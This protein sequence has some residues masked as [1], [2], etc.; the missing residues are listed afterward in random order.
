[1]RNQ[2]YI[3]MQF[4][5][6]MFSSDPDVRTITHGDLNDIDLNEKNI[7]GL[8]HIQPIGAAILPGLIQFNFEINCL[9]IRN[10]PKK[11]STDK[12]L[13]SDNEL[14]NLNTMFAVVNNFV[15]KLRLQQNDADID[16]LETTSPTPVRGDFTNILDGWQVQVQLTIPNT[17]K[18]C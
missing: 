12:W 8:V 14:D 16:I 4:L 6:E 18:V 13:K 3:V 7:Y 9:D 15:T 2:F 11:A 17:I 5:Y 1:M 10:E